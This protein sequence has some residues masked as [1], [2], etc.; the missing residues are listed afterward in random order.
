MGAARIIDSHIHC[1]VQHSDLPFAGMAPL[2]AEAGITD[3]CLFAPVE[4]IY[5]RDD[6]DFQDNTHWQQARRAANRYLLDLADA[7]EAIFP[8]LFVWNDFAIEE[9]RRPYRGIKWHR[10]SYEPIYHY[11]DPRCGRMLAEITR[12]R[13]PVVLEESF[14]NTIR[15][16][17]RLAPEAVIIIPHLGGLNGGYQA[18]DRAGVWQRDNVYADTALASP[19]EMRHFLEHYGPHKLLFGSDYPFGLPAGELRKIERLDLDPADFEQVVAGTVLG[20]LG[21]VVDPD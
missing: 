5:D 14:D 16:I 18:L 11:D 20:L 8:Y 4:D 2:L 1:G 19:Q 17:E 6:Y 3:A 9:L 7:G 10:H 15:F 13:L 21:A 12:R